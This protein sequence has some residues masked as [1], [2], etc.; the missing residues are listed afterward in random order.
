MIAVLLTIGCALFSQPIVG[1]TVKEYTSSEESGSTQP[2]EYNFNR[3]VFN[4][5]NK[6]SANLCYCSMGEHACDIDEN[7]CL[8]E[9]AAACFHSVRLEYNPVHKKMEQ[10]HHY[11]C[12]PLERGGDGSYLTCNLHRSP[13]SRPF[14]IA[15]CYE[16]GY[17][18]YNI[19]PP[20]F[21]N[22][23][24]DSVYNTDAVRSRYG[25]SALYICIFFCI[26]LVMLIAI[27]ICRKQGLLYKLKNK[28]NAT[29][30]YKGFDVISRSLPSINSDSDGECSEESSGAGYAS[31]NQRTVAQYLTFLNEVARGRYGCVQRA[32]YRTRLVAVKTFYTSEEES[33]RNEKDIY[34]TQMLNHENILQFVAA[35]ICSV[36]SITQMLLITDYHPFGSLYDYL[37]QHSFIEIEEA[38]Q[39]TQTTTL[40]LEHLHTKVFGTASKYKPEIAHRDIKS[41]NI[42]VKQKGICCIADFGLAVRIENGVLKPSKVNQQSGTR[43]YMSPE[44]LSA[45]LNIHNFDEFKKSDIY[46][47]SLVFWEVFKRVDMNARSENTTISNNSSTESGIAGS[48]SDESNFHI[49]RHQA[50]ENA[51]VGPLISCSSTDSGITESPPYELSYS[52]MVPNDPTIEEMGKV[53]CESGKR[54]PIPPEW[55]TDTKNVF[56]ALVTLM[57]EMWSPL[58]ESRHTALKVKIELDKIMAALTLLLRAALAVV[59]GRHTREHDTCAGEK[60]SNEQEIKWQ[61][62]LRRR[63][64]R[65]FQEY[66]NFRNLEIKDQEEQLYRRI[67]VVARYKWFYENVGRVFGIFLGIGIIFVYHFA[68][69]TYSIYASY[70]RHLKYRQNAGSL[71]KANPTR[72]SHYE[73]LQMIPSRDISQMISLATD[74]TPVTET[75]ERAED[76]ERLIKES[77]FTSQKPHPTEPSPSQ[78]EGIIPF[79][80]IGIP[81]PHALENPVD[82]FWF[83][84]LI[85][86]ELLVYD[87]EQLEVYLMR[88]FLKRIAM[89]NYETHEYIDNLV[90]KLSKPQYHPITGSKEAIEK[91]IFLQAGDYW[92]TYS[93]NVTNICPIT[94]NYLCNTNLDLD[95]TEASPCYC[96]IVTVGK[97]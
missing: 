47:L 63:E 16:G 58:P 42:I 39:L 66:M 89:L 83:I 90:R 70:R 31:L 55:L 62:Q 8:K 23:D 12:A 85:E 76:L 38:L 5:K 14:S 27:T 28:K 73:E 86:R 25:P 97:D 7:T 72:K 87:N 94:E 91:E 43:R 96:A 22:F 51:E 21:S 48:G 15:C 29:N 10:V 11:G 34:L 92:E 40:G 44:V 71:L 49:L 68:A 52:G 88:F 9:T 53:V 20:F 18:N 81:G 54:P 41:K 2:P 80:K 36:D 77:A 1:M 56:P 13:H 35:D 95:T 59:H 60:F 64:Q 17:C 4:L 82:V 75:T 84:V 65:L 6:T 45:Q 19:T 32:Y 24:E 26:G 67:P 46:S 37:R 93:D 33:W 3:H 57:K 79:S 69:I 61:A 30:I 50:V 78:M 74:Y